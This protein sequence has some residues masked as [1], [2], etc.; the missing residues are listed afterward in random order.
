MIYN[1]NKTNT[2]RIFIKY[3]NELYSIKRVSG[4]EGAG[5]EENIFL[6]K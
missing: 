1:Q 3:S 5:S 6:S 2:K 4:S